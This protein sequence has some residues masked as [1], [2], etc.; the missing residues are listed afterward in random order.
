MCFFYFHLINWSCHQ[1]S[2]IR[3]KNIRSGILERILYVIADFQYIILLDR[4]FPYIRVDLIGMFHFH[5]PIVNSSKSH[6]HN[7]VSNDFLTTITV[8]EKIWKSCQIKRVTLFDGW[9]NW[10]CDMSDEQNK[11][12]HIRLLLRKE[13]CSFYMVYVFRKH[14]HTENKRFI[15][16]ILQYCVLNITQITKPNR[17]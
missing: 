5:Y 12:Q 14:G 16:Q 15:V 6:T 13:H 4:L 10:D 1:Q 11:K 2:R 7:K 3:N 9:W 8:F 17:I